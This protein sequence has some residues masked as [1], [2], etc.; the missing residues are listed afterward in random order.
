M[1][2][3]ILALLPLLAV[4]ARQVQVRT[5]TTGAGIALWQ[6]RHDQHQQ[7]QQQ[8]LAKDRSYSSAQQSVFSSSG[9]GAGVKEKERDPWTTEP[10][11]PSRYTA[12]CFP[13]PLDHYDPS[14]NVTL[15]QRYWVSLEHYRGDKDGKDGVKEPVYLLDGGETS[16][17]NR[18]PFMETGILNILTNA[19]GGIGIVL[20]HRYY[21]HS[22]PLTDEHGNNFTLSTDN[23]RFLT[24]EQALLDTAR[25]VQ[26]LDLGAVDK[27]LNGTT[28]S[29]DRPWIAYG[30]SYAGAMTAFL[31]TS[32]PH[33]STHETQPGL[34]LPPTNP[35]ITYADPSAPRPMLWGGI[36]SSAVT[37]A[38]VS[39]P[40]YFTA[41]Q[42]FAPDKC[43]RTLEAVVEAVDSAL[44]VGRGRWKGRVKGLFGLEGLQSDADFADVIA[45]PLGSWQARNWDPAGFCDILTAGLASSDSTDTLTTLPGSPIKVPAALINYAEYVKDNIVVDC[46]VGKNGKRDVEACFGSNDLAKFRQTGIEQKWRLWLFQVCENWGYFMPA[47]LEGPRI[48]S[49]LLTL[50]HTSKV[51]AAAFPPGK[52]FQLPADGPDVARVNARGDFAIAKDRLAFIDGDSDPWRPATPQSDYALKRNDTLLRPVKLIPDAVHHFDENGLLDSSKEPTRIRKVH[53]EEMEFVKSWLKEWSRKKEDGSL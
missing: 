49:K 4:Q 48:V 52:L 45:S 37:H 6:T 53:E 15:C 22:L 29:T 17:A 2:L 42:Q 20:E 9:G 50:N 34:T 36:A 41:I 46:P 43:M 7:Q 32:F 39:Y 14:N 27:R 31:V 3:P 16:G 10:A 24:S 47:P 18:L 28:G 35:A 21:G 40:E 25:L 1:L 38:Q 11:S 12:H 30:G 5:P 23:L 19:T 33:Q 8:Q 44:E 26:Y 51:C 13:Q